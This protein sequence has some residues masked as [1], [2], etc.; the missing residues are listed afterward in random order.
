MVN[1]DLQGVDLETARIFLQVRYD[2]LKNIEEVWCII[3]ISVNV[4][5][6]FLFM[7]S[8]VL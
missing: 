4:V 2:T 6:D 3:D 8:D 1:P 5:V 7:F